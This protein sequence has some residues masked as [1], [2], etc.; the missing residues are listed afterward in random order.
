MKAPLLLSRR[1]AQRIF[2]E[3]KKDL[4]RDG[5]I[6]PAIHVFR[7][8]DGS[9]LPVASVLEVKP[10][11]DPSEK[12]VYF[13]RLKV[14]LQKKGTILA[15]LYIFE[16]PKHKEILAMMGRNRNKTRVTM[17]QQRHSHKPD[18][19]IVWEEADIAEYNVPAT[20]DGQFR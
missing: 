1:I 10:P 2:E 11:N 6:T 12:Q 19:T 8:I 9:G 18:G 17:V 13:S 5:H 14:H 3:Y 16:A 4:S 15:A 20:V 7:D